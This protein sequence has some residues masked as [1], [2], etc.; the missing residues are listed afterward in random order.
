VPSCRY[1][2]TIR[3]EMIDKYEV[4]VRWYLRFNGYFTIENFIVHGADAEPF[5]GEYVPAKT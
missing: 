4:F 1:P 3:T 2:P 5:H